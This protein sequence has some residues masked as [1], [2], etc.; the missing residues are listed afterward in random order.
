MITLALDTSSPVGSLAVL[1][2]ETIIGEIST[3]TLEAY[4]SRIF[5]HLEFLLRELQLK[6]HE[7]DL[8]AVAAGPG[9]FT[10]LR[11]GLTAAKAWAEA[12]G[13]P[14]AA[15]SALEAIAAQ[16]I[17][18][19]EILV[20][21]IDARRGEVYFAMYHKPESAAG[22]DLALEG[23]ECSLPPEEFLNTL[24]NREGSQT[25]AIVSPTPEALASVASRFENNS[26]RLERVSGVLAPVI[27]RIGFRLAK[28]GKVY[29]SLSLDANYVRRSDAE[30]RWK[31]SSGS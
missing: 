25:V 24:L 22:Q 1:R 16:S 6:L 29:D 19:T 5:R 9:S 30:V 2:D 23:E 31:E 15:V 10:G 14:I 7:F 28:L 21:V 18:T 20:P 8:F 3:N 27:G 13:K 12:Y 11:V 17:S 4:S 26:V